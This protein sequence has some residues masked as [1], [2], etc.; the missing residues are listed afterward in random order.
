MFSTNSLLGGTRHDSTLKFIPDLALAT[1]RFFCQLPQEVD[2]VQ[3]ITLI[4][5][6]NTKWVLR[7]TLQASVKNLQ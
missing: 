6:N 7:R 5:V 1:P 3:Y 4:L 2:S